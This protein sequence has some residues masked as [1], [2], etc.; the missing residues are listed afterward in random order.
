MKHILA[1]ILLATTIACSNKNG[2]Q[3]I[4][5]G[6]EGT[7]MPT[8]NMTMT[9]TIT[10]ISIPLSQNQNNSFLMYFSPTCPYCKM[11]TRRI[12]NNI[13]KLKKTSFIFI[14]EKKHIKNINKFISEFKTKNFSN[15]SIAV[16]TGRAF[17]KYFRPMQMPF[18]AIYDKNKKLQ[19][20]YVGAMSKNSILN[21]CKI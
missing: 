9:D 16:D 21:A 14:T 6:K 8:F 7:D 3:I 13:E 12:I 18:S 2:A 4:K 1:Y 10:A 15:I 20:V 5:T 11:E 19:Q 17:I